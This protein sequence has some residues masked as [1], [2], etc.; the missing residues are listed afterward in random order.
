L[1][2]GLLYA[3]A[4]VV[5]HMDHFVRNAII[6]KYLTFSRKEFTKKGR[7]KISKLFIKMNC[8]NKDMRG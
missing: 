2:H 4:M 5:Q 3:E 8:C 1:G 6:S 7:T